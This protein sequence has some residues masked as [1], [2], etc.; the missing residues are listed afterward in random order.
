MCGLAGY[1]S[2]QETEPSHGILKK[3]ADNLIHR[4]PDAEG[5]YTNQHVGFAH[6]RLKIIDLS[7]SANQP[8]VD[9]KSK[10]VLIFNGEIYNYLQLRDELEKQGQV[11]KTTSDTEVLLHGLTLYGDQFIEKIDGDFA[12]AFWRDGIQEL[13]L[14]RDRFGVKP[15]YLTRKDGTLW[16]ASEIKAFKPAGISFEI[17]HAQITNYFRYRYIPS[18]QTLFTGIE[19]L[20]PGH[21]LKINKLEETLICYFNLNS[22]TSSLKDFGFHFSESVLRRSKAD[23]PVGLFLSGGIDSTA[24]AHQIAKNNTAVATFSYSFNVKNDPLDEAEKAKATAK[25]LDLKNVLI[26][27]DQESFRDYPAVINSLEEPIGDSII[28]ANDILFS[29]TKKEA[30]VALSGE[31]ADELFSSYA[32]HRSF[33][34]VKAIKK[35]RLQHLAILLIHAM[36]LKLLNKLSRYPVKLNQ[37]IKDRITNALRATNDH[38]IFKNFAALFTEEELKQLLKKNYTIDESFFSETIQ[39][40]DFKNWLPKYG[41]LRLDKLSMRHSLEIRVPFLSHHV[42]GSIWKSK[43]TKPKVFRIDKKE[44]RDFCKSHFNIN[45]NQKKQPFFADSTKVFS[46]NYET[47][48]K[49]ALTQQRIDRFGILNFDFI[50]TLLKDHTDFLTAKKLT[51]ILVFQIWC[52]LFLSAR[53]TE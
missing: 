16:F 28:I 43:W 15:L 13:T 27:H 21:I 41:L 4:G 11:F 30:T 51:A 44:F 53:I 50:Q 45:T 31:G 35:I 22:Q 2:A 7:D 3:M 1:F 42:V 25:Q 34:L 29:N 8:M 20:P 6:R 19:S 40:T 32:H 38:E 39:A 24:T 26:Q 33:A 14:G 12:F 5:F 36:P 46:K 52:E 23:R 18:N 47:Y 49:E 10:N 48:L 37:S 17:N 9:D